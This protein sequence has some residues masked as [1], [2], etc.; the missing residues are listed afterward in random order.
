MTPE[1]IDALYRRLARPLARMLQRR[2]GAPPE[3]VDDACAFAWAQLV[4]V[5][6]D[7]VDERIGGWLYVVASR[8]CWRLLGK[9]DASPFDDAGEDDE[10]GPEI[11]RVPSPEDVE[12]RGIAAVESDRI[13]AALATLKPAQR[14]VLLMRARG[15]SYD[16]IAESTGKTYTWVNRHLAEGKAALKRALGEQ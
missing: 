14:L 9:Q 16:Q 8:E 5:P 6:P 11:E 2:T 15:Y 3:I 13:R 4:A 12:A 1:E 10:R 7:Q